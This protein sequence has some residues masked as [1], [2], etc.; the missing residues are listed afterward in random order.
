MLLALQCIKVNPRSAQQAVRT[1][2]DSRHAH[3][4]RSTWSSLKREPRQTT[5]SAPTVPTLGGVQ[6]RVSQLQQL[7]KER[8][9]ETKD[10][11]QKLHPG[12]QAGQDTAAEGQATSS[13]PDSMDAARRQIDD[14]R[15]ILDDNH[16][17]EGDASGAPRA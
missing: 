13:E 4:L 9:A 7:L 3:Q 1:L 6:S 17:W 11:R 14:V 16:L 15:R 12:A 2:W 10:L 5:S 8:E